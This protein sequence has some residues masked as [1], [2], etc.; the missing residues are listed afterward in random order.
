MLGIFWFRNFTDLLL[1]DLFGTSSWSDDDESEESVLLNL[2]I[3]F[4]PLVKV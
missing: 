4:F 2:K 3:L 1:A